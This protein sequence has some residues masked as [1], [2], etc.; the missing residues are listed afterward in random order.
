VEATVVAPSHLCETAIGMSRVLIFLMSSPVAIKL[1]SAL[2]R[3]TVIC[4]L[5]IPIVAGVEFELRTTASIASAVSRFF[6]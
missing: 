2:L 5:M 1:T 4:P 6:G 3:P